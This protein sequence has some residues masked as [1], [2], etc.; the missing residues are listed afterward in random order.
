VSKNTTGPEGMEQMSANSIWRVAFLG[1]LLAFLLCGNFALAQN[2][3]NRNHTVTERLAALVNYVQSRH[4]APFHRDGAILPP[5]GA[6]TLLKQLQK[7]P[8]PVLPTSTNVK[9]N[10]DRNPWPKAEEGAA[11]DPTN[12]NNYV[13]MSNDFRENYDHMFYHVST[14]GGKAWTDD[15]M[16]G[17]SDPVT[18]FIPLTF[19][20]DPGVAFD[21]AGHSFLSTI[22]GNLI[23]DE[24]NNY[25]TLTQR[26]RWRWALPMVGTPIPFQL[27]SM[28]SRAIRP[29]H[30]SAAPLC[31]TS[32]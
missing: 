18:G 15:S 11:V 28:I 8:L 14:N 19:Q 22:T 2:S 4:M 24:T 16:T 25:L 13:V 7:L 12:G 32:R 29:L 3:P 26:S 9:V 1:L 21:S 10:R 17:G 27:G 20:S 23:F 6:Q 30:R 5:R 31:R